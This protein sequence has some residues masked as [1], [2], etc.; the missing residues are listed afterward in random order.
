LQLLANN[1]RA[2]AQTAVHIATVAPALF[3]NKC[4]RRPVSALY[5]NH[6]CRHCFRSNTTGCSADGAVDGWLALDVVHVADLG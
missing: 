6:S 2:S 1:A 3:N 4:Q 5:L